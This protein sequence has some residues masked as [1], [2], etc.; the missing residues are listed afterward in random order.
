MPNTLIV[1]ESATNSQFCGVLAQMRCASGYKYVG[2]IL[3]S[4]INASEM[5]QTCFDHICSKV[6][7]AVFNSVCYTAHNRFR[8]TRLSDLPRFAELFP[9]PM[10]STGG[11]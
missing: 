8:G 7:L 11:V 10:H 4:T 3:R 5:P 1:L 9:N 2:L 6:F